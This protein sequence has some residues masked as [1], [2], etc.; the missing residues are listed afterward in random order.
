MVAMVR[1]PWVF[2]DRGQRPRRYIGERRIRAHRPRR[3]GSPMKRARPNRSGRAVELPARKRSISARVAGLGGVLAAGALIGW[4]VVGDHGKPAMKPSETV[5][6]RTAPPSPLVHPSSAPEP[7]SKNPVP[8][9]EAR[10]ESAPQVPDRQIP[11][12]VVG[13]PP[14]DPARH[15]PPR[16]VPPPDPQTTRPSMVS[17]R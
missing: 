12:W 5:A 2:A 9:W 11:A 10:R 4:F 17:G 3:D 6:F 15:K 1:L 13:I 7:V 16:P 8:P 14:P